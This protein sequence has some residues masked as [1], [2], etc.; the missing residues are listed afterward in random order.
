MSF[1]VKRGRT[2][3]SYVTGPFWYTGWTGPIRSERQAH[4]EA[5]AWR[6]AGW[7][8]DIVQSTPEIRAEVR[9]WERETKTRNT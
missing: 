4:R 7:I 8:A 9:V 3:D 5:A 2:E 6:D 1:Y